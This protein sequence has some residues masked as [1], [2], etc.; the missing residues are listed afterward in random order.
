MGV[1]ETSS[2]VCRL[3]QNSSSDRYSRTTLSN[4]MVEVRSRVI[5]TIE[6]IFIVVYFKI[7]YFW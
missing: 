4:T 5:F 3:S 2:V 7:V 6:L 1:T